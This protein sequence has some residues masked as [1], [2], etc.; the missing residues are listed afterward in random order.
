MIVFFRRHAT[1]HAAAYIVVV[2]VFPDDRYGVG[3]NDTQERL[4]FVAPRFRNDKGDV[5]IFLLCHSAGESVA[6]SAETAKDMGREL[7]TEH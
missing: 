2:V 3:A 5:H 1:L 4:V 6:G 7:P